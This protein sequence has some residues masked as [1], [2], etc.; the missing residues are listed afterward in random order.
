MNSE[1]FDILN[2]LGPSEESLYYWGL[3]T[4]TPPERFAV[5]KISGKCIEDSLD[6]IAGDLSTLNHLGLV[7]TVTHGWGDTL[8]QKL[9][10]IGIENKFIGGDRY[11]DSEV[12][13]EVNEVAQ[14]TAINLLEAIRKKGGKAKI[15]DHYYK[16]IIAK[17]KEDSKYGEHNGDIVG[18]NTEPIFKTISEGFIP[19]VTPIGISEDGSKLYN[20]NSAVVGTRI[21]KEVDPIKYI[22]ATSTEGILDKKGGTISE[23]VLRR[24]YEPLVA[25]GTLWGGALKN[26]DES[27]LSINE[28]GNSDD[29]SAQIVKPGNFLYELFTHKGTG[30]FIRKGYRINKKSI[31]DVDKDIVKST[32][33]GSFGEQL[34]DH[35]F[36]E[37]SKK[38][39]LVYIEKNNKGV[40]II[41]DGY[42]DIIAVDNGHIRKGV[43]SDIFTAILESQNTKNPKLHWRSKKTRDVNKLYFKIADGH[44]KFVGVDG[45]WY[46]GFWIGYGLKEVPDLINYMKQKP[47]NFK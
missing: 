2:K 30:T 16:P 22:M 37:V 29:K 5:F 21:V 23:I 11:T 8:T 38:D 35:Y 20:L 10:E 41:S 24:D 47:P 46:N 32:I 12:M 15:I 42:L 3:Y 44:K 43:A 1:V 6:S 31:H 25:D 45:E 28:R 27:A 19:I 18:I 17:D 40:A 13:K 34:K 9:K 36:D 26:V 14:A 7:P 33:E 39:V 4:N